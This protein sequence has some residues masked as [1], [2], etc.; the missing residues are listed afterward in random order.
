MRDRQL[1]IFTMTDQEIIVHDKTFVPYIKGGG[2][3]RTLLELLW[4]G[5]YLPA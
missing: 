3:L 4:H 1:V 2:G 5:E